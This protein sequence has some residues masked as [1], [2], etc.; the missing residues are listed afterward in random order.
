MSKYSDYDVFLAALREDLYTFIQWGYGVLNPDSRFQDNW[1]I[2]A[3][4][5]HLLQ[6]LDCKTLRLLITMPPRSLKSHCVS[7]ALVAWALGRNP[8]LK[9]ICASYG[10][11]PAN[12]LADQ[13]RQLMRQPEYRD[14][15]PHTIFSDN[16]P[17]DKLSTT[18][19]GYRRTTSVGGAVTGIGAD[20]VIADDLTK[21]EASALEREKAIKFYHTS[22]L[23]RLND[24]STGA[25]IVVAQRTGIDDLPGYLLDRGCYTHLNLA[26][27]AQNDEKIEIGP[28]KYVTRRRGELLHAAREGKETLERLRKELGD[29]VFSAQ[30]LQRPVPSLGSM[31]DEQWFPTYEKPLPLRRYAYRVLSIDT[32]LVPSTTANYTACS[33]FGCSDT[34]QHLLHVWRDRVGFE[35]QAAKIDRLIEEFAPTHVIVEATATGYPLLD[36][37]MSRYRSGVIVFH[38][39]ISREDRLAR[40]IPFIRKKTIH[41]PMSAP[42][43]SAF[44][45]EIFTFPS[46]RN[47]DQLDT[48][49]QFANYAG[50][51]FDRYDPLEW[52]SSQNYRG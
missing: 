11:A 7:V 28:G 22:L 41:F 35:S 18:K 14:A 31:L 26:A 23:S 9:F 6:V 32:A 16:S 36:R 43:L 10:D 30:Y 5:H 33:I 27:I 46:S 20:I 13:T 37:L 12:L 39:N 3:I 17:L 42:W 15:F 38:P 47:D 4:V 49:V 25:A 50:V 19:N 45:A 21:A 8:A 52:A 2:G 24:K 51:G 48:L 44:K 34:D 40:V 29:D 1:H